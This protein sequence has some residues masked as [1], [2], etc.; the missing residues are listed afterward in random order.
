MVNYW[1]LVGSGSLQQVWS[2]IFY[3]ALHLICITQ[4]LHLMSTFGITKVYIL[5]LLK[6]F[7]LLYVNYYVYISLGNLSLSLSLGQHTRISILLP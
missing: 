5:N 3:S 2:S 4:L 1:M 6:R 7:C